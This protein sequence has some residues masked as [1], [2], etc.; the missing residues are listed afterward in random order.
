MARECGAFQDKRP[1]WYV[2]QREKQRVLPEAP[3]RY[4]PEVV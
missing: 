1:D 4:N 3:E 2:I